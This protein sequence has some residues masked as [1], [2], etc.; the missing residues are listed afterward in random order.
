MAIA[1]DFSV[2]VNGDI[3]HTSGTTTYT[4]L[5]LHRFLQDL[6]DNA[7]TLNNDLIDITS[8]NPSNRST[9]NIIT[10]NGTYNIDDTAAEYLYDGS[11]TQAS[12]NTIYSGLK[13]VG[14]VE[15][16]TQLMI[17]QNNALLTDYWGTGLNE[18]AASNTLL[19]I[20]V[21]TRDSGS[22]IDGQ[23][24]RVMAREYGDSYAEFNLTCGLGVNTAAIFTAADLNNQTASGTV[25][26]Y[27][28]QISVTEGY[29]LI[30]V[31]GDGT[32]EAYYGE[33]DRG[34]QTI[35]DLYEY[36][37]YLTRRG[38]SDTLYG[39]NGQLFRGITQQF[40]YNSETGGDGNFD[41]GEVITFSSG[42]TGA[43]LAVLDNGT[44]GTIWMQL[45][46]GSSP[47]SSDTF[48]GGTGS[49]QA[50][51]NGAPTART[52][53][54]PF[55]GNSTGSAIIGSYGLGIEALDLTNDD[56]LFD[57]TNTVRVPPN[58][59]T[60]TV[61]SLIATEDRVLVG[62]ASGGNLDVAQFA[63]S[64]ALTGA[65]VTSI[66]IGTS[67]PNDTPSSGTIRVQTDSGVY[68]R[69]EYSSYTGAVFTVAST[70]FSS[71]NAA[72]A[73]NVFISYIDDVA[74]ATSES[75]TSV[76]VSNR[77]LLVRVRDGGGTPTKGFEAP[78]T[79]TNTGGSVSNIRTSDE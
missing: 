78:A 62:P 30:D 25:S 11:I 50:T 16:G 24:L 59:V 41:T 36:T 13:V 26:G 12:G 17:V 40:D 52:I 34:S 9:D 58:L 66:T 57:L 67:I 3:R 73:N 54:V 64:G 79:L 39:M 8:D 46:T 28:A 47:S 32:S 51:V 35:N 29:R 23:R 18:D 48:T 65:A 68:K 38:S 56:Q 75:F 63:L 70:D 53:S 76:F 20:L 7:S 33:W 19:Q 14:A 31:D 15:T 37:K 43:V 72:D 1:D 27:S 4:V 5:E 60:F 44:T 49:T 69:V 74:S 42:G 71:D 45:L 21:R 61:S 2:A 22:D 55:I 77:D 6:A 10:L